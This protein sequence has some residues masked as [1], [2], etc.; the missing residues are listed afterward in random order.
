MFSTR[1]YYELIFLVLQGILTRLI[2]LLNGEKKI[3]ATVNFLSEKI[4]F[5]PS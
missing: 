1:L 3:E 5:D 4:S 2:L